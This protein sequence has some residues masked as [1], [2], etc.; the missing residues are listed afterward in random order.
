[1]AFR[2]NPGS[3]FASSCCAALAL[4]AMPMAQAQVFVVGEKSAM[5]DVS[6]DFHPT[7]V[8][9]PSTLIGERGRRELM[10]DL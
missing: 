8:E 5:A 10:R 7:R 4:A 3:L 1:M 9:L 6:T 2:W